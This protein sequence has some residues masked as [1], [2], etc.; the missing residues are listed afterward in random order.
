MVTY[1][2]YNSVDHDRTYDATQVSELFDGLIEPGVYN[3]IGERF[4]VTAVENSCQVRVGTG[5]AWFNHTWTKN[6]APL[7][8]NLPDPPTMADRYRSDAIVIDI[9]ADINVRENKIT[10]VCGEESASEDPPHPKLATG[11]HNQ[12]PLAFHS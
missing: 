11:T 9:N 3:S 2:F 12:L 10:Y 1:G 8:L 4:K 6:D 7:I 5:R